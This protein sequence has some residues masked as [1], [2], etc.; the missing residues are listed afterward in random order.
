[1][2]YETM[3]YRASRRERLLKPV[4]G[5]AAVVA[6][7][8]T[9]GLTIAGPAALAPTEPVTFVTVNMTRA[10]RAPIEVAISPASIHVVL[11]RVKTAQTDVPLVPTAYLKPRD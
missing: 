5:A 6:A 8:A 1:M 2:T 4:F 9:L 7:M 11:Q 3:E 10:E